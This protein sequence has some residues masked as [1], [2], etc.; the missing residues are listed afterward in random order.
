MATL[1]TFG[2]S[3]TAGNGCRIDSLLADGGLKYYNEY[4]KE[5]DD[6][7]PNILGK[8]INYKTINLGK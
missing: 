3:F 7:W 2:D 4:K 8:K 1:W 6:I 5:D